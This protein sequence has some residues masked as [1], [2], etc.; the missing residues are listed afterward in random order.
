MYASFKGNIDEKLSDRIILEVNNIG[1]EIYLPESEIEVLKEN[2]EIKIFTYLQV[3]ED[4]MKLFG[5]LSRETLEFFKKLISVSGVGPKVALGIISNISASDMCIAIATE[6]IAALKSVPGIGPKM[7][8]KIVFELKDKILKDQMT[9]IKT[10]TSK[11]MLVNS[12]VKEAITAL[13]VLGYTEKQVKEV[14][15]RI[16]INDDSVENIIRKVLKEMQNM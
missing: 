6:N 10:K 9:D 15:N 5:F 12:N 2:Q 14:M 13:Q 1:Y 3:R 16:A 11:V 4:D 7:A 8:Q